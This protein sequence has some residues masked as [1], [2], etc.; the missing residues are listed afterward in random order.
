LLSSFAAEVRNLGVG[1]DGEGCVAFNGDGS[2]TTR[3]CI[4]GSTQACV[5][6]S[7]FLVLLIKRVVKNGDVKCFSHCALHRKV[8]KSF[9]IF[10]HDVEAARTVCSIQ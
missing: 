8:R 2:Y 9:G 1:N 4:H 6:T 10:V 3:T 5:G 7:L